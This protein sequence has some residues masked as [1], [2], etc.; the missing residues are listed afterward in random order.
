VEP[1]HSALPE[2]IDYP[3]VVEREAAAAVA[4]V[5][6]GPLD[7]RV[8]GCPDWSLADL[9]IHLGQVHRWATHI[10]QTGTPGNLDTGP[11]SPADSGTYL[12]AGVAPLLH[13]LRAAD[14][15]APCWNFTRQNETK[16]FWPRRQ[17]IETATHRWDAQSALGPAATEPIDAALASDAIDE[18]VH[19]IVRRVV[20]RSK[21]DLSSFAGDLHLHCTDVH[22]EWTLEVVDGAVVVQVGHV[23][24]AAAVRAPA[25]DLYLYL[26][27][28]V[29]VDRVERFGDT[30]LIDRWLE[31][32]R[33]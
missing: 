14:L 24:A 25:S 27:N 16:S 19:L 22:G 3:A 23:K 17:A 2:P 20:G 13:E 30:A 33:F 10:V 12:A 21:A 31:L 28:R 6:V 32:V 15:S 4:A 18:W 29:P 5:T 8:P 26:M 9:A 7:A 1:T 11:A